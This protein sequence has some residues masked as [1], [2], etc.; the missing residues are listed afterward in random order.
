MKNWINR[1]RSVIEDDDNHTLPGYII[2]KIDSERPIFPTPNNIKSSRS[3]MIIKIE[4]TL[5]QTTSTYKNFV[6]F[7]CDLAGFE[8]QFK[9]GNGIE[10][11]RFFNQYQARI[12][13]SD[14]EEL[15]DRRKCKTTYTFR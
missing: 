11:E 10:I 4:A 15:F 7:V 5:K 12:D 13:K 3:H 9:C 6:L 1:N 14:P 8:N 2:Q